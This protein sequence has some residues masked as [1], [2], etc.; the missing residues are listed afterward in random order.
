MGGRW[1]D[2]VTRCTLRLRRSA[3]GWDPERTADAKRSTGVLVL[4]LILCSARG[5]DMN[6]FLSCAVD[7][8]WAI[9]VRISSIDA[10]CRCKTIL[11]C[12]RL[13][14]C[15][16]G[17]TLHMLLAF[18]CCTTPGKLFTVFIWALYPIS[19]DGNLLVCQKASHLLLL[20]YLYCLDL[21]SLHHSLVSLELNLNF[22][23]RIESLRFLSWHDSWWTIHLEGRRDA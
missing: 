15:R 17:E 7:N 21:N 16:D 22:V 20:W 5:L 13:Y 9:F 1:L 3:G 8:V 19:P 12:F 18:L 10:Q 6:C 4:L 23:S 14:L 11:V 2:L